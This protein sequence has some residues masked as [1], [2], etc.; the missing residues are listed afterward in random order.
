[1]LTFEDEAVQPGMPRIDVRANELQNASRSSPDAGGPL[2]G[3]KDTGLE[4]DENGESDSAPVGNSLRRVSVEDKRIINCQ[5]DVNQ[6]VPFKYKWAWDKYLAACANHW[7]PQEINMSRGHCPL[8]GPKW[9]DR[10]RAA[11]G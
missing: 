3:M 11:T 1:M 6:L 2:P 9:F 4:T 7:M 5:A 10:G 8:E